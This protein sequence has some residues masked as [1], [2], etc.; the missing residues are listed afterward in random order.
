MPSI[1]G[2][3][4]RG[5]DLGAADGA[6]VRASA[7]GLVTFAGRVVDALWVTVDHGPIR[8]T[9]GPLS[10]ADVVRGD[11]V[12]RGSILG[13]AGRAHGRAAVHWSARRGD[14][15]VDPLLVGHGRGSLVV[16]DAG[17]LAT[18]DRAGARGSTAAPPPARRTGTAVPWTRVR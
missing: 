11:R 6:A 4:H 15:Y 7:A 10:S 2:A 16:D 9:V 17:T 13:R 14:R 3:G 12:M 18:W 8:T 1:Y 5:V